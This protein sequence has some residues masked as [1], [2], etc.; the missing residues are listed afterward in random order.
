V[1]Q[2]FFTAY[3]QKLIRLFAQRF[4]EHKEQ[5]DRLE[6]P[7]P[8]GGPLEADHALALCLNKL[9]NFRL[10]KIVDHGSS[11]PLPLVFEVVKEWDNSLPVDYLGKA[12]E[13]L[14]TKRRSFP[15]LAVREIAVAIGGIIAWILA[16]EPLFQYLG[17][18]E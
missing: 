6:L 12:K 15:M 13:P 3:E 17:W 10:I 14:P 2:S 5:V 1:N 4:K 11:R 8:P 7:V 16:F 9:D 18:I